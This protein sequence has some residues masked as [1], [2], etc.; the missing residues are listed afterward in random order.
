[1]PG[2]LA[3]QP[4]LIPRPAEE[5]RITGLDRLPK[6]LFV[7]KAKHQDAARRMVLDHGWEQAIHFAEIEIH[8]PIK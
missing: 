1:M 6:S 8:V 3:F 5:R 2:S 7:H 4:K